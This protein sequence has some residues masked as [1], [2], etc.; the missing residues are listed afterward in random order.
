MKHLRLVD[1]VRNSA[2]RAARQLVLVLIFIC[3]GCLVPGEKGAM[4][5]FNV[6]SDAFARDGPIPVIYT[7]DGTNISPPLSW[8]PVPQGTASIAILVTDPDAPSGTFIHWVAYNIPP[9]IREIPAGGSEEDGATRRL[10][11]GGE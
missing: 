4:P 9:G 11:P 6:S 2:A 1:S 10:G 7:C 5:V 8:G 3:S